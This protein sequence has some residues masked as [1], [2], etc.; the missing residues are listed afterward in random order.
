[1]TV[2][3][4]I[5]KPLRGNIL[6]F[7][8]SRLY[9]LIQSG[10]IKPGERLPPER[11]LAKIFGVSRPTLRNG[12]RWLTLAGCLDSRQGSGTF[13]VKSN[14]TLFNN[15][16]IQLLAAIDR[17]TFDEIFEAKLLLEIHLA[18]LAAVNAK[19]EHLMQMAE[20]IAGMFD[21]VDEPEQFLSHY[22]KFNQ[23]IAKA[24]NNQ[25]LSDLV[26]ALRKILNENENL[27]GKNASELKKLVKEFYQIYRT[28]RQENSEETGKIRCACLK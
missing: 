17:C 20:S 3:P 6:E 5:N 22:L 16:L 18:T 25:I 12:I 24:S 21:S 13:L 9:Y 26:N 15:N 23:S 7:I 8:I 10:E 11:D 4:T 2:S 1:M 28:I 19:S 14:S 27:L